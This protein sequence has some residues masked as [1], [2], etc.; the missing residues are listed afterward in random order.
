VLINGTWVGYFSLENLGWK[1]IRL[2]RDKFLRM[3]DWSQIVDI[4]MSAE[5]LTEWRTYR[6]TLRDIPTT[7]S[8]PE[9]VAFP[10]IPE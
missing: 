2:E 7:F 3:S 1:F 6:Q 8:T 9:E 5:K 4:P 10:T